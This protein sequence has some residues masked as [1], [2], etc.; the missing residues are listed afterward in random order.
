MSSCQGDLYGMMGFYACFLKKRP[1]IL[2]PQFLIKKLN[3]SCSLLN[4]SKL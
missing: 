4:P 1:T 2:T 3:K